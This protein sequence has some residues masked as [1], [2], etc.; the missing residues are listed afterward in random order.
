MPRAPDYSAP[1]PGTA[2]SPASPT[3]Y[4]IAAAEMHNSG[5]LAQLAQSP[6]SPQSPALGTGRTGVRRKPLRIVR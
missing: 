1:E 6:P 2:Y 4:L 3:D 5:R